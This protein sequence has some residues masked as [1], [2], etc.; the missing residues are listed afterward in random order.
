MRHLLHFARL[1]APRRPAGSR[2][3]FV[4]RSLLLCCFLLASFLGAFAILFHVHSAAH[5]DP[6]LLQANTPAINQNYGADPWG[7]AFDGK[8][9]VWVAEPQCDG[10]VTQSSSV[11]GSA[12]STGFLEYPMNGFTNGSP[13]IKFT[14]PTNFS[15]PF[16]M[17][18]DSSGNMW[19]AE[20]NTNAI[21]EYDTG[22]NW[23][24]WTVPTANAGPFDLTIDQYGNIWFTEVFANQIGV[25][26]PSSAT[27]KEYQVP[28]KN[29]L[30]YAI[31]GPDPNTQSIWFT[32]NS[33][34]VHR[35]GRLTPMQNGSI[36]TSGIQEY[37]TNTT[38]GN[39]TPH[40]ITY[41]N[42]GNIWWSEGF[43]GKIGRLVISQ[44]AND[45][46]NGVTEYQVPPPACP[47]GSNC[48][49]HISGIAV[50]G[51]GQVWFDDSL[52]SRYGSFNPTTGQFSVYVIGSVTSN[53]HPYDGLAV[54][55]SNNIWF[56]D[57]FGNT[58]NEALQGSTNGGPTPTPSTSP[59]PAPVSGPVSKQWYFAEGRAGKGF[60]E[61][62][63]IGNPTATTCQASIEYLYTPDGGASATKNISF[64][65]MPDTRHTDNVD[66]DLG[67][68]SAG[69]GID[70]SAIVT[71]SGCPGVVAERPEYFVN[72]FGVNSGH[73]ALG[74]THLGTSFYF[75]DVSTLPGYHSFITILNPPGGSTANVQ[76]T[77]YLNGTIQGTDALSVPV[78]TRGTITPRNLGK[79]VAAYVTSSQPVA[80]ELPTYFYN[81]NGGNSRT[82]SG[83]AVVVGAPA[84]SNDWLFAEGYTGGQFQENFVIAN[85]DTTAKTTANVTVKLEFPGT[86]TKSYTVSVG[87]L[88]QAI[89]NVNAVA[90]GQEVSAEITSTGAKI[91]VEREM[92]FRYNH[93][94]NGR[95]LTAMGGSDVIGQLGPATATSYSFAEG[96]TATGYD[97]WLTIQNPTNANETLTVTLV[98]GFGKAYTF[99]LPV[100]LHSRATV[101]IVQVVLQYL[102]VPGM[103]SQCWEVSMSVQ[104]GGAIFVAERPMYFNA[105]GSQ[106]G[107]DVLGYIGN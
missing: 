21:G 41:D 31:T 99:I 28:S 10:N 47:S 22:A 23:H 4:L 42:A 94:A 36:S 7:V 101:D 54:D 40:M 45:T 107:T 85:L 24:Q 63:T 2:R 71:A 3:T 50:D 102:C 67:T 16:F 48:G 11:C 53:D 9:H 91:V 70:V 60:T 72:A 6:T 56:T 82:V 103:T 73:D 35:I 74:A 77:Y 26:I 52:S 87:T 98:N 76:V 89:F 44:A 100:G 93:V 105:S 32:E 5:A 58:L 84:L 25:F 19:F 15:Q 27:F 104:A 97:E 55:G 46:S 1:L 38:G 33:A 106:G 65:I 20:P 8:G 17:K 75:A 34:S 95:S 30:P 29:S 14:E 13:P 88:N 64:T 79:R 83:A 62:L 59:T 90:P 78:G 51:N 81:Y 39:I 43:D 57:E 49:S 12:Y 66:Q 92:F 68:S 86:T 69:T 61:Y 80:V 37:L 18:F 96:Y